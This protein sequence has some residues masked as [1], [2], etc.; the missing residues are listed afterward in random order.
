MHSWNPLKRSTTNFVFLLPRRCL[1]NFPSLESSLWLRM[2]ASS[3]TAA[4][5]NVGFPQAGAVYSVHVCCVLTHSCSI[6][7]SVYQDWHTYCRTQSALIMPLYNTTLDFLSLLGTKWSVLWVMLHYVLWL[8]IKLLRINYIWAELYNIHAPLPDTLKSPCE[9][10]YWSS[11]CY[12]YVPYF[13]SC[14]EKL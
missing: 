13:S 4:V 9:V 12:I 5:H 2:P 8:E 1:V 10:W 14:R 6:L 3:C 11:T 7:I